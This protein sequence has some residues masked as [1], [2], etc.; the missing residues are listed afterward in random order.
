MIR[1]LIT[2]IM[3]SVLWGC[4]S[5]SEQPTSPTPIPLT[6]EPNSTPVS[7]AATYPAVPQVPV[8]ENDGFITAE[9]VSI[10]IA[11]ATE[12]YHQMKLE[13]IA[14]EDVE[15]YPNFTNEATH[16]CSTHRSCLRGKLDS[17]RCRGGC[18]F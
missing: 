10:S 11:S 5:S 4:T 13:I 14:S 17:A 1:L 16:L 8:I 15:S 3:V 7:T 18:P 2:L 9:A 6:P 12:S